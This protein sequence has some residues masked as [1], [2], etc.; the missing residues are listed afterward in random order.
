MVVDIPKNVQKDI[1]FLFHLVLGGEIF[2]QFAIL[3]GFLPF[4]LYLVSEKFWIDFTVTVFTIL[5]SVTVLFSSILGWGT[6][7]CR[8]VDDLVFSLL[9][10]LKN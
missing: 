2:W 4:F 10:V 8:L 9:Y 3:N 7:A 1:E 6:L 5:V